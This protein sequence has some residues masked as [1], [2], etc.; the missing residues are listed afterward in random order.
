MLQSKDFSKN[1]FIVAGAA[2]AVNLLGSYRALCGSNVMSRQN[3]TVEQ[4]Y[5]S[6][7]GKMDI[8]L[9]LAKKVTAGQNISVGPNV[10]IWWKQTL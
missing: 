4:K 5:H 9:H 10:T 6:L 3:V 7:W 2:R 8:S 1:W